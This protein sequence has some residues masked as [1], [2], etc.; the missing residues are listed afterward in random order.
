M[1]VTEEQFR[2]ALKLLVEKLAELGEAMARFMQQ[3][4]EAVAEFV[5]SIARAMWELSQ[6]FRE[7]I[8]RSRYEEDWSHVDPETYF[9]EEDES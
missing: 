3:F 2:E 6:E 1:R 7:M 9:E 4:S 8:R 5:R